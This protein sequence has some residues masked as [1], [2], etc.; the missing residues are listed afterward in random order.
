MATNEERI[1]RLEGANEHLATKA[2]LQ[3]FKAEVFKELNKLLYWMMG[4]MLTILLAL[5]LNIILG[6]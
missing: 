6:Q 2:D 1:S 3:E 5:I 4:G